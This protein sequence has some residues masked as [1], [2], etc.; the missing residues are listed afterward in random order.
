LVEGDNASVPGRVDS[1]RVT[2]ADIRV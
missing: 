1:G 2:A